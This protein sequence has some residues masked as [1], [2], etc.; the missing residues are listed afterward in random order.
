M[1]FRSKGALAALG[2]ALAPL[3]AYAGWIDDVMGIFGGGNGAASNAAG[4]GEIQ[5]ERTAGAAAAGEVGY[6]PAL[7][8][9]QILQ[10]TELHIATDLQWRMVEAMEGNSTGAATAAGQQVRGELG[11]SGVQWDRGGAIDQHRA[12]Y[13]E[14]IGDAVN[15]QPAIRTRISQ[16]ISLK[17][18]AGKEL[19]TA[20][21]EQSDAGTRDSDTMG[22]MMDSIM[23]AQGPTQAIQG[24]AQLTGL[25]IE[26]FGQQQATN[27]AFQKFILATTASDEMERNIAFTQRNQDSSDML[28]GQPFG[29]PDPEALGGD[30]GA[31]VANVPQ[32]VTNPLD[33]PF[34]TG[35]PGM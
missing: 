9:G 10:Y 21:A 35:V 15:S 3:P 20:L 19:A 13:V 31:T 32:A 8:G 25:M 5:A 24:L 1:R 11:T 23:G 28:F 12:A 22:G 30:A 14:Q 33:L 2:M 34:P 26:K 16:M 18:A 17:T 7:L 6:V 27:A 4:Q 29:V